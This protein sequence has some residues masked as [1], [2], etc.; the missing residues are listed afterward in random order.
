MISQ[1]S[2]SGD[3][4]TN[5]LSISIAKR[6]N[7][8]LNLIFGMFRFELAILLHLVISLMYIQHA[9]SSSYVFA[10]LVIKFLCFNDG[11]TCYKPIIIL[12]V[13]LIHMYEC[14][15]IVC[16]CLCVSV[17]V[18]CMSLCVL[19]GCD[20]AETKVEMSV[21]VCIQLR[22]LYTIVSFFSFRI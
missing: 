15:K 17:Y 4:L 20:R 13:H 1:V 7:L 6:F 11:R 18:L 9:L 3:F 14:I 10:I 22:I 8:S 2:S 12:Q 21:C 19:N 5:F 16:I